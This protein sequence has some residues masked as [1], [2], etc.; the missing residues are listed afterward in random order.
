MD[1]AGVLLAGGRSR[2][3]GGGDKGLLDIA[4]RPMLAHVIERLKPQVGPMVINANGDPAAFR[5][6]GLPVVPDTVVGFA[7]PLAGV[8][9]GM[10]W[11]ARAAPRGAR[12]RHCPHR[13][14]VPAA[15]SRRAPRAAARDR[16]R[17]GS[18][19]PARRRA[20]PRHRP[21]AGGARR[22]P[23]G[24]LTLACARCCDL[25]RSS[26]Y[27]ARR[28]P[29]PPEIG[30]AA[31]DPFFNA[32]TPAEL[33]AAARHAREG[34]GRDPRPEPDPDRRHRR[35]EE[36]GQDD[37]GRPPGR[38]VHAAR[39]EVATVKHA[40]H[41]FQIDDGDTDSAR[42]RRAGAAQVAVVSALG[43]D[44]GAARRAGAELRGG[45]RRARPLPTRSSWRGTSRRRSRRSRR[46]GP[47]RSRGA[48]SPTR[49]R[50][51]SPSPPIIPWTRV[52]PSSRSTTSAPSPT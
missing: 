13:R 36:V 7:G 52:C 4:G 5:A 3:M 29:I 2:R 22:R 23:R 17:R 40:H 50:S 41:E 14:A 28:L 31:V 47:S 34:G 24:G 43:A 10:R 19:S 46:A 35:L 18:R 30:G 37:A 49:T 39:P 1:V 16:P 26:R 15:G 45:D 9:A 21:V 38:G 27:G 6:F 8:L 12:H 32:N 48:R 25:D 33:E 51:S 42:H 44:D 11:A 20:A